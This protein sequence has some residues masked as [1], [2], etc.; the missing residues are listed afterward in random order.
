MQRGPEHV[1]NYPLAGDVIELTEH[2]VDP[3]TGAN[4]LTKLAN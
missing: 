3:V 2:E 1:R 4:R